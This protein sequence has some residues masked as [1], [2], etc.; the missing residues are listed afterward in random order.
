MK[1]KELLFFDITLLFKRDIIGLLQRDISIKK[2]PKYLFLVIL[3]STGLF[4]GYLVSSVEFIPRKPNNLCYNDVLLARIAGNVSQERSVM[5]VIKQSSPAVV[6]IIISKEIPIYEEYIERNPFFGIEIPMYRESGTEKQRVGGGSGFIVSK[7]GLILT[8]KHVV[9]DEN[10]EFTVITNDG[11]KYQAE[12]LDKDPV[13]DLAILKINGEIDFPILN[14]GDSSKAEIGQTVIVIG[15]ALGEFANS[16]SVGIISGLKRTISASGGGMVETLED[17]IQTDA[18]IN[19]GNSGG[20][21]LNLKG[22]VI[23]VS[24]AI[25]ESAQNISFAIP[26]NRAKRDIQQIKTLGKITYPFLG[27]RY[28]MITPEVQ[29][30]KELSVDYGILIIRGKEGEPAVVYDSVAFNAGLKENDI[31]LEVNGRKIDMNNTLS[32][33]MQEFYPGDQVILKVLRGTN[34][35]TFD[36]VLGERED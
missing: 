1:I 10:A 28:V 19:K 9:S 34:E 33:V 17:I 23:G 7:Q 36:V 22:E 35:L 18:A 29:E 12:V 3:F 13:Q 30:E 27:I 11:I 5:N 26:I 24:V 15:N 16:A 25:A 8:N 2:K 14:L 6:S 20:P 4:L 21:L 31:I 32:S